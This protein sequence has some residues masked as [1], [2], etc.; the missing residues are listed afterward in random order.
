MCKSKPH[1]LICPLDWGLGHASRSAGIIHELKKYDVK[2]SVAGSPKILNFFKKEFPEMNQIAFP[3]FTV[4]YTQGKGLFYKLLL[5]SPYFL[6]SIIKEHFGIIK[7][8]RENQIDILISDSRPGLWNSNIYTVL[9][10]HQLRI[11]FPYPLIFLEN[12]SEII[13]RIFTKKFN[14]CWIPDYKEP[15][16]SLAGKLSHPKKLLNHYQYVG[17]ISRFTFMKNKECNKF[18]ILIVL[19]GPEPQRS[20]LEKKLL[21]ELSESDKSILLIRGTEDQAYD[22]VL[23]SNITSIPFA[24]SNELYPL[25]KNA[26]VIISRS[27]YST[28][29]DL[30][31]LNK[32]AI[33]IPTPGQT[34]QEY[35]V[36]HLKNYQNFVFTNQYKLKLEDC[37]QQLKKCKPIDNKLY[38]FNP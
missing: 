1:I 33:L 4:K 37:L 22:P 12:F 24:T 32:T 20:I 5:L 15:H 21:T 23:T 34:E 7:I 3:S 30:I 11:Q 36:R 6:F 10:I 16:N 13:L 26:D 9:L 18:D 8:C 38:R 17:F 31:L 2:I 19:S 28:L 29:M 14:Q 27:G 35:L 25:I